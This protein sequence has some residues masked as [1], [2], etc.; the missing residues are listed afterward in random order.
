MVE[1]WET[2]PEVR[3]RQQL[4]PRCPADPLAGFPEVVTTD[5]GTTYV[6]GGSECEPLDGGAMLYKVWAVER[7]TLARG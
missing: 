3:Y 6:I 4:V 7:P 5:R 2:T 1:I